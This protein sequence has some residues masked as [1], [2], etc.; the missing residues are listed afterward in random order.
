M[1]HLPDPTLVVKR[2]I[3][4]YGGR[5]AAWDALDRRHA[6]MSARWEQ[7]IDAIG[8]ILRSHLFV[9]HYLQIYIIS[10]NPNLRSVSDARLSFAQTLGLA[11]L[12]ESVLAELRPGIKRL[13]I[14]RNRLAH[15]L[16]AEVTE[17]DAQAF[18]SAELFVAMRKARVA[19]AE[20][21][22]EPLTVLEDFARYCGIMLDSTIDNPFEGCFDLCEEDAAT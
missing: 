19:P 1:R 22:T 17:D 6:E 5:Q 14:V 16:R 20:P 3:E 10:R 13:N 18:L 21:R 4:K 9:E 15:N 2:V 12:D 8:R 11:G 7:D